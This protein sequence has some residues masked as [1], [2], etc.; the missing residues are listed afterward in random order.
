MAEIRNRIQGDANLTE[1][2]KKF[3]DDA[4]IKRFLRARKW[5][6][7]KVR[8]CFGERSSS[9]CISRLARQAEEMLRNALKWRHENKIFGIR[10]EEVGTQVVAGRA[11]YAVASVLG[12]PY[13]STDMYTHGFD[14][15]G[16]PVCVLRMHTEHGANQGPCFACSSSMQILIQT[17]K[18]CVSWS[19]PWNAQ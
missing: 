16:R 14:R 9:A 1:V 3:C 10:A 15:E 19:T 8:P 11:F 5:D 4:C 12:A 6:V 17:N 7:T 18:N 13:R 2:Q